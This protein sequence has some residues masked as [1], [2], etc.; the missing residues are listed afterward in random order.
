M[1]SSLSEPLSSN[2]MLFD[3][4]SKNNY[5]NDSILLDSNTLVSYSYVNY[6]SYLLLTILVLLL[7]IRYSY[8]SQ[9]NPR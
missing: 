1:S 6:V 9:Q 3:T 5:N 8:T 7:C 4:I 2:S